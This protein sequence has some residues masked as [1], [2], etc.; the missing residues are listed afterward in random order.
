[1][2]AAFALMVA[3]S[4]Q[5]NIFRSLSALLLLPLAHS[6]LLLVMLLLCFC[7]LATVQSG[8]QRLH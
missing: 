8:L 5:A 2:V 4:V 1:M 6:L 7:L 3:H